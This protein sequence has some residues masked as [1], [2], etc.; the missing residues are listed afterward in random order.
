VAWKIR[1]EIIGIGG[2]PRPSVQEERCAPMLGPG[3]SSQVMTPAP[4]TPAVWPG[5]AISRGQALLLRVIAGDD[6]G[7]I[8]APAMEVYDQLGGLVVEQVQR[9][10][11]HQLTEA[12]RVL[13]NGEC[14]RL[15]SGEAT[16]DGLSAFPGGSGPRVMRLD[17]P[18]PV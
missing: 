16:P 10:D 14:R 13:T 2:N 9:E 8:H 6:L 7:A 15:R 4:V 18:W 12:W 11:T 5:Q 1:V 3:E 17:K